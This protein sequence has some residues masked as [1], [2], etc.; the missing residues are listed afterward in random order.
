MWVTQTYL[1][2]VEPDADVFIYYLFLNYIP[3]Q[4]QFTERLQRELEQLG[5][6]FGGKASLL[7]PNPRYAGKIEAEVRE[8]RPLWEAVYAKLPGLLIST[9]PLTKIERYDDSCLFVPFESMNTLGLLTAVDK[10][11]Q[12]ADQTIAWENKPVLAEHEGFT[13]RLVDSL[14][15]KPGIFGF[16]VDLRKLFER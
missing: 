8:I 12:L 3:E 15:L 6:V 14:E 16:R 11:K 13:Q 1:G 7:M 2:A 9:V 4:Q 5:D 10:I